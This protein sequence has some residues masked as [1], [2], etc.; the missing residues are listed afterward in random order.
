MSECHHD[1]DLEIA[2]QVQQKYNIYGFWHLN[3][4]TEN[5]HDR[6]RLNDLEE[7]GARSRADQRSSAY[8]RS[9]GPGEICL[10]GRQLWES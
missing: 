4:N 10:G 3:G 7:N 9:L 8:Y 5:P 6:K 2:K 1:N